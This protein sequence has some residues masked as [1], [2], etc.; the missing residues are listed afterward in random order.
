MLYPVE[1]GLRG[2]RPNLLLGHNLGRV[3][4]ARGSLDSPIMPEMGWA[5]KALANA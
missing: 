4:V 3:E 2:E 5:D 1:L